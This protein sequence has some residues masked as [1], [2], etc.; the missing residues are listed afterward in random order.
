[1]AKKF[2]KKLK[3]EREEEEKLERGQNLFSPKMSDKSLYKIIQ[4]INFQQ[5]PI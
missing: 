4:G 5:P 2:L 1:M 3:K